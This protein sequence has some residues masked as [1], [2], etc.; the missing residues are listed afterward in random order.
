MSKFFV[1]RG[2]PTCPKLGIKMTQSKKNL[3][4]YRVCDPSCSW[5]HCGLPPPVYGQRR[6]QIVICHSIVF[7]DYHC[8]GARSS[9]AVR[10]HHKCD[11]I[12]DSKVKALLKPLIRHLIFP[13]ELADNHLRLRH[14]HRNDEPMIYIGHQ[15][16][17]TPKVSV[18]PPELIDYILF[19]C[20]T[21]D[22]IVDTFQ[23]SLQKAIN[24][25]RTRP[26][27]PS[28][29]MYVARWLLKIGRTNKQFYASFL[30][31]RHILV[32]MATVTLKRILLP[33]RCV[34]I[35]VHYATL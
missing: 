3:F 28:C 17:T 6:S 25:N 32:A 26:T 21:N 35:L 16:A 20:V 27:A 18:L 4:L 22:E 24:R 19:R 2:T 11:R 31:Y 34:L 30:R 7:P 23:Q 13:N 12:H 29:A 9:A 14:K 15:F 1:K 5:D 33:K 8:H 10:R